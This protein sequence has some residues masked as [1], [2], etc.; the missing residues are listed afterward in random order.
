VAKASSRTMT[1]SSP[2]LEELLDDLI[3]VKPHTRSLISPPPL[4]DCDAARAIL[5]LKPA[6]AWGLVRAV[7]PR[8]RK[9]DRNLRSLQTKG[10]R[11]DNAWIKTERARN[12]YT[13]VLDALL[14]RKLPLQLEDIDMLTR[15]FRQASDAF[16]APFA[17]HALVRA[18]EYFI[19]EN[20]PSKKL[21]QHVKWVKKW[22]V[23]YPALRRLSERLDAVTGVDRKVNTKES[24]LENSAHVQKAARQIVNELLKSCE[25]SVYRFRDIEGLPA[26]KSILAAKPPV[27]VAVLRECAD[28]IAAMRKKFG[29]PRRPWDSR[30][31]NMINENGFPGAASQIIARLM[32]R[33]LP[34]TD[35]DFSYLVNRNADLEMISTWCL[36]YLPL[37][38]TKVEQHVKRTGV[39]KDVKT[40]LMRLRSALEW[41]ENAAEQKLCAQIAR[42]CKGPRPIE[43]DPGEAWSDAALADLEKMKVR[44][45]VAWDALLLHCQTGGKGKFTAKM[46][47]PSGTTS[48]CNRT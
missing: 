23:P 37:V 42:L 2:D 30:Y 28:R 45:R 32:R 11:F 3:A 4:K 34:L 33:D 48:G 14:V 39:T 29:K 41:E 35:D 15:E 19:E 9:V 31:A 24:N 12:C 8:L 6:E 10:P 17:V 20:P 38:V 18:F 25:K 21:E 43:I 36:T 40:A 1:T 7:F 22:L 46:A 26:T 5:A 16:S 44:R 27:Q 13:S 47:R